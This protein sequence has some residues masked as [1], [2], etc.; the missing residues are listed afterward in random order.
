M[1]GKMNLKIFKLKANVHCIPLLANDVS[2]TIQY[3]NGQTRKQECY[4]GNSFLSQ[5]ARFINAESN[6]VSV[7]IINTKGQTRKIVL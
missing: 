3:K 5:S 4:F 2:A 6:V 7:T 1:I